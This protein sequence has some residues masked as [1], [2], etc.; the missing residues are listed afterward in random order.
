MYKKIHLNYIHEHTQQV[1]M[2]MQNIYEYTTI[3][4]CI[5]IVFIY[6]FI[7][8]FKLYLSIYMQTR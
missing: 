5:I 2:S 1:H 4:L 3:Q 8:T 7:Y 6:I